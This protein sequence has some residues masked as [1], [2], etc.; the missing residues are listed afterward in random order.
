[1]K[2]DEHGNVL[3]LKLADFGLACEVNDL[4]YA[5]CGTPTY[6]APE[7]LLEVGYGLKVIVNNSFLKN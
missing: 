3:E 4:L 5:V 7:I 1:M 6:V 2:L